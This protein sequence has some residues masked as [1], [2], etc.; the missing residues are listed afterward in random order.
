MKKIITYSLTLLATFTFVACVDDDKLFEISDFDKGALLNFTQTQNDL[1]FIDVFDLDNS[2]LEFTM[3]FR[4]DLEQSGGGTVQGSG[5]VD[6]NLEFAPVSSFDVEIMWRDLSTGNRETGTLGNFTS[7]PQTMAV[8]VS[9]IVSS[10]D[11][12]TSST[13]LEVGDVLTITS[14]IHLEDGRSLPGFVPDGNNLPILAFSPSFPGQPGLNVALFYNVAC[15]SDLA[16]ATIYDLRVEVTGTCCGLATEIL[17]G[18]TATVTEA[19]GV[20]KYII[21]DALGGHLAPFGIDPEG[22]VVTDVCNVLT[23]D[24]NQNAPGNTLQYM[25][26]SE[27]PNGSYDPDSDTWIIKWED[28]FGNGIRGVTTL[29]PQ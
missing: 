3:D 24:A 19:P 4:N 20:G 25:P 15:G 10:I 16:S 9:D 1:G 21:S 6:P 23:V 13:D 17:T 14:T 12:L 26:N 5:R 18:R 11:A 28:A 7:W 8:T 27:D 2:L 29:I 22:V